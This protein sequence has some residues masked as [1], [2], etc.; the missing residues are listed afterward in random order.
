MPPRPEWFNAEAWASSSLA[1]VS[2]P[3]RSRRATVAWSRRPPEELVRAVGAELECCPEGNRE[4]DAGPQVLCCSLLTFLTAPHLSLAADDVPDLLNGGMGD[5][6]RDFA[7]LKLE[8]S[9]AAE[10]AETAQRPN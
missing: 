1:L 10:T 5:G 8:V 3:L 9:K 6:F 7:G 4:T 2:P